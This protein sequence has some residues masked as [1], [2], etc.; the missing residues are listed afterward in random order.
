VR[1]GD[2]LTD[3][4]SHFGLAYD[5]LAPQPKGGE[6]DVEQR[7]EWLDR[8]EHIVPHP[9]Y[10]HFLRLWT[11]SFG[12]D[13][14]VT[15]E[16]ESRLLIGHGNPSG[17]DVG[18][19]VHQTWG[20]PIIPGSSLKGLLAHFIDASYGTDDPAD[21]ARRNWRG[22]TWQNGR[23]ASG[24]NAGTLYA[25]LFGKP[26]ATGADKLADPSRTDEVS[27]NAG[28]V[29]FHDA[30]WSPRQTPPESPFALDVLT[31]H[32]PGYYNDKGASW[33]N[34]WDAPNPVNFIT[35]K[36]RARFVIAL[37]C[38]GQRDPDIAA[39]WLKFAR[40]QLLLALQQWG[41]GG[42]TAAGYGRLPPS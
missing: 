21:E 33:P 37:T 9:D 12:P 8:C 22:P 26:P 11:D 16:F 19:T 35:V 4:G 31:V 36:P 42:K 39:Q 20:V 7:R 29:V 28:C 1:R 14:L 38:R 2:T 34:D 13:S 17:A 18:L 24:Q 3:V 30:L 15:V 27:G 41:V 6:P 5:V 10:T 32:Q 25:T 40:E 23:V